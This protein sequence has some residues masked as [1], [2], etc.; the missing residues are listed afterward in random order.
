MIWELKGVDK[1]CVE[2]EPGNLVLDWEEGDGMMVPP[3]K[4]V[5]SHK[6]KW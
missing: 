6:H 1:G 3:L 2:E 4:V 5:V